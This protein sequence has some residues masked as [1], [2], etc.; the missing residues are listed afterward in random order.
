MV[1]GVYLALVYIRGERDDLVQETESIIRSL[2][3]K[4]TP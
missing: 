4:N 3:G 1:D 2:G